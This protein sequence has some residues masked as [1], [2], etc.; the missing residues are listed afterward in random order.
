MGDQVSQSTPFSHPPAI[1]SVE[2]ALALLFAAVHTLTLFVPCRKDDHGGLVA[3]DALSNLEGLSLGAPG[4]VHN[5]LCLDHL[6]RSKGQRAEAQSR[7]VRLV[8]LAWPGV[9]RAQG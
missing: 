5:Y 1:A 7:Q 9:G 6:G 2:R 8:V 3:H 4:P